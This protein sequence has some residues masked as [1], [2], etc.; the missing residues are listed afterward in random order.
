MTACVLRASALCMLSKISVQA[1]TCSRYR[2]MHITYIH[3]LLARPH[4]AF[5]SQRYITKF[6]KRR[7]LST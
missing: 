1:I 3:T 2:T 5:Q 7:K 6:K 4:E